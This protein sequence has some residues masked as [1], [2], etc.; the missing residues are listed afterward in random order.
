MPNHNANVFFIK[1]K[2]MQTSH[3]GSN[4][5]WYP[6]AKLTL[7][8]NGQVHFEQPYTSPP[9]RALKCGWWDRSKRL[10]ILNVTF[11]WRGVMHQQKEH[12]FRI[13]AHTEVWPMMGPST[14]VSLHPW[15]DLS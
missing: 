2:H 13:K 7:C 15:V 6:V 10:G 4:E 11:H 1:Y 5:E 8:N 12:Y 3:A 9:H 14:E